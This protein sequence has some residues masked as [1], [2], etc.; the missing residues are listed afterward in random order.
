[1]A[2]FVH[3]KSAKVYVG[4]YDL[5]SYFRSASTD[6]S[7]DTAE[8]S[9]F[10]TTAKTFIAGLAEGSFSAEGMFDGTTAGGS[11]AALRAAF[12][13]ASKIPIVYMPEG[14]TAGETGTGLE[15]IK[16]ALTVS[17]SISD[18]NMVTAEAQSCVGIESVVSLKALSSVSAGS[19]NHTSVDNGAATSAGLSAY[20]V[21]TALT[22]SSSVRVQHSSDNSNWSDLVVFATIT[23]GTDNV[24]E[25]AAASGTVNRYLRV[26]SNITTGPA[27]Y[28]VFVSRQP[29]SVAS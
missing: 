6:A 3:G 12:D 21:H 29:Y 11:H 28:A 17:S 25:R 10:G 20:L 7:R 24:A 15:G 13:S 26:H 23:S 14:D 9:A 4:G 18:V 22:G 19:V 1:M 8:T 16:T 5:T 2:S 27:V